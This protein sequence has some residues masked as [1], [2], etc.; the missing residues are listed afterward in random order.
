M[1]TMM[2]LP[3]KLGYSAQPG[4]AAMAV[5]LDSPGAA[6]RA[7]EA[8]QASRVMAGWQCTPAEYQYLRA[9]YR[10]GTS[11]GALPF[12]AQLVLDG[13]AVRQYEARFVPGSFRLAGV[14]GDT[15]AVSAEMEVVLAAGQEEDED[16]EFYAALTAMY[17]AFG[18]AAGSVGDDLYRIVNNMPR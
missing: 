12:V 8:R 13:P 15:L 14:S 2:L 3:D 9:L 7:A 18:Q 16:E 10:T 17:E 6:Y 4:A 1:H 11:S 5:S